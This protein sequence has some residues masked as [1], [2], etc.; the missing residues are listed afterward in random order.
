MKKKKNKFIKI[1]DFLSWD[2]MIE[3]I[4]WNLLIPNKK[5]LI[6]KHKKTI[7]IKLLTLNDEQKNSYHNNCSYEEII[8]EC[9]KFEKIISQDKKYINI[10]KMKWGKN[11]INKEF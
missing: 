5:T 8:K 4:K 3:H 7:I 1:M 10:L 9:G 11:E 2:E 6:N